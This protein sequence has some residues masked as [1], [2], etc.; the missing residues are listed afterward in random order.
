MK[1][2]D[3]HKVVSIYIIKQSF[4]SMQIKECVYFLESS[5]RHHIRFNVFDSKLKL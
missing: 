1:S 3:Y 5:L 4:F 2:D